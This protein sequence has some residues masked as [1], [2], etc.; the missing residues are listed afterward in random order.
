MFLES[1]DIRQANKVKAPNVGRVLAPSSCPRQYLP[2]FEYPHFFGNDCFPPVQPH[3]SEQF[4]N[5]RR[6]AHRPAILYHN[7]RQPQSEIFH[8]HLPR[9]TA[10]S[11]ASRRN[12]VVLKFGFT[13]NAHG[14]SI[15]CN[16]VA[17]QVRES[18]RNSGGLTRLSQTAQRSASGA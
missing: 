5:S 1:G 4:W 15:R 7:Q 18:A 11:A 16:S 6:L 14:K 12:E 17:V 13:A 2:W 3:I 8:A 10:Q 9:S